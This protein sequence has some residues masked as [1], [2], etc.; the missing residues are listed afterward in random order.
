MTGSTCEFL[1]YLFTLCKKRKAALLPGQLLLM[2]ACQKNVSF[3]VS[4]Q[5]VGKTLKT[6]ITEE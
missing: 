3:K 5:A 2:I 4:R 1:S 6:T